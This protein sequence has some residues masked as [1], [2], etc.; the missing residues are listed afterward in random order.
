MEFHARMEEELKCPACRRLYTNPVQLPGCLHSLCLNCAVRLQM[1]QPMPP[2]ASLA[3][4]QQACSPAGRSMTSPVGAS[5][6]E[7][8]IMSDASYPDSDEIS[9]VSETDSGVVCSSSRPESYIGG[10]NQSIANIYLHV[11]SGTFPQIGITCPVCTR[12][13]IV[14]ER[15]AMALPKTKALAN[16]VD[17]YRD[18]KQLPVGCQLCPSGSGVSAEADVVRPAVQMCEQCEVFYCESCLESYHPSDGSLAKHKLY[19]VAEGKAAL[20]AQTAEVKCCEHP[21]ERLSMYCV[22]CKMAVCCV[23]VEDGRHINHHVQPL[24]AMCKTQKVSYIVY[25][26]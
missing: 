12:T 8:S 24:G 11:N 19:G 17:R 4:L 7:V 6:E 13:A 10:C 14:D 1:P 23:C 2:I 5:G 15:G 18:G 21:E 26:V 20:Q 25:T 9:M 16:I 22:L 3:I